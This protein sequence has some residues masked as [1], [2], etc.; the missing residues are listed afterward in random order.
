MPYYIRD[1]R[2]DPNF[3]NQPC[4]I[5]SPSSESSGARCPLV[6]RTMLKLE[7]QK[8][9]QPIF[10]FLQFQGCREEPETRL[11]VH[12]RLYIMYVCMYIYIYVHRQIDI[13]LCVLRARSSMVP[14]LTGKAFRLPSSWGCIWEF[15]KI[16]DPRVPLKGSLKGSIRVL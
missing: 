6:G 11:L 5:S 16:G 2:R 9:P 4:R 8:L 3:D 7:R 14:Y 1:P 12:G 10:D 15:P 13:K